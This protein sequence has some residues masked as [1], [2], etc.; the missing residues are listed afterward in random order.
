MSVDT[1]VMYDTTNRGHEIDGIFNKMSDDFPGVI[2][3]KVLAEDNV[4]GVSPV[5]MFQFY[6]RGGRL[7]T[8]DTTEG[9]HLLGAIN[10]AMS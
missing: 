1:R 6:K 4:P 8:A 3:A 10:R 2:F 7:M 9:R 5:P